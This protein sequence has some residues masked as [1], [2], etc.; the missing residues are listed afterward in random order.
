LSF[1]LI[2]YLFLAENGQKIINDS[3]GLIKYCIFV[4]S[5]TSPVDIRLRVGALNV[6]IYF[7]L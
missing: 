5:N 1:G 6:R 3:V 2:I 7:Y 4:I